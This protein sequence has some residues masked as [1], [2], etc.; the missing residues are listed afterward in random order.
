MRIYIALVLFLLGSWAIAQE[1]MGYTIKSWNDKKGDGY[2]SVYDS[3]GNSIKEIMVNRYHPMTSILYNDNQLAYIVAFEKLT[4]DE[5]KSA[6]AF[7]LERLYKIDLVTG[8]TQVVDYVTANA[9]IS[10]D[11]K[12]IMYPYGFGNTGYDHLQT[13]IIGTKTVLW[14]IS[15]KQFNGIVRPDD[16]FTDIMIKEKKGNECIL[17]IINQVNSDIYIKMRFDS[18]KYELLKNYREP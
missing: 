9:E 2:V 1:S 5:I 12:Y 10:D 4:Q 16:G 13:K 18:D 14:E 3:K 15:A 6:G 7:G 17:R 8:N 11:H